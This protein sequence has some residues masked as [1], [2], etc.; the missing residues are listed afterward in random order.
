MKRRALYLL[1]CI[2]I[3]AVQIVVLIPTFIIMIVYM[4]YAFIRYG[5]TVDEP[6]ILFWPD[7][8]ID[9]FFPDGV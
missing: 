1:C 8:I 6:M 4:A 5:K 3:V 9:F 7:R 2:L